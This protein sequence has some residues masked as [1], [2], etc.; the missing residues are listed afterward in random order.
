[1]IA[2]SAHFGNWYWPVI[3]AAAE[4]YKVNAIV[5]PL[6]NPLLDRLMNKVFER[7][8]VRVIARRNS[9][10]AALAA[11]RRGETVALMVDQNAAA[12]GRFVPFFD[13]PAATMRGVALLRKGTGAEV[14]GVHDLRKG[15]C[16]GI[17]MDWIRDLGDDEYSCLAAIN[18]Y[19]EEVIS[20]HKEA[21]FWLHPRWK[22]RPSGEPSLYP[23]LRI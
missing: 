8:G 18:R 22:K 3:C 4:G 15:P 1:V 10:T 23:G 16:H 20:R 7:W 17:T 19:F 11:L 6:D 9:V 12:H 13:V 2:V 21:Y 5:R 14:V